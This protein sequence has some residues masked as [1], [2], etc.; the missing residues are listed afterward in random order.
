[1]E[2]RGSLRQQV[3]ATA[4]SQ[5]DASVFVCVLV[6][7]FMCLPCVRVCVSVFLCVV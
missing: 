1:M 7:V 4:G 3:D 5:G 6:H 2:V